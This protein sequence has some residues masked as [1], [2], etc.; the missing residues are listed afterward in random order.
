[1]SQSVIQLRCLLSGNCVVALDTNVLKALEDEPL[2]KWF[3]QFAE[4]RE[5]GVK[6]S[7]P[8]LCVGERLNR[9]E[10]AE[11]R[12]LKNMKEEWYRMV[13]HLD[14]IIW[15]DLPCLPLRGDLYD[16]VGIQ[17]QDKEH[18][19][20]KPFSVERA[21]ELYRFL[22]DYANSPYNR[23]E[24]R[25]PC[26]EEFKKVRREWKEW[27]LDWRKKSSGKS[28][29]EMYDGHMSELESTFTSPLEIV[30]LFELPVRF[31]AECAHDHR[32][33][34][35]DDD[36]CCCQ[37]KNVKPSND[38]L[39]YAI[40]FLTM[41]SINICSFDRLFKRVGGMKGFCRSCCCHKPETIYDKWHEGNLPR[42]VLP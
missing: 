24:Q 38:G 30:S 42:V 7:I 2:P 9:F 23:K 16:L 5:A 17:E 19:R 15:H 41:A 12:C 39:D 1:M 3:G 8:E 18:V 10:H 26:I 28:V 6:F 21:Q 35:T 32:Y 22:Y 29:K 36:D 4:M 25:E 13:S 20:D 11:A 33:F 14:D 40:L 31:A 27:I 37:E 34:P